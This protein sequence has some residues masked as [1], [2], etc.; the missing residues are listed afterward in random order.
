MIMTTGTAT[1]PRK[2]V[3][4]QVAVDICRLFLEERLAFQFKDGLVQRHGR[5]HTNEQLARADVVLG[6]PRLASA[7][8]HW[9]KACLRN[10]KNP[11]PENA[12]KEAVCSVEAAGRALF[13]GQDAKTLGDLVGK[14]TGY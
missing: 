4:S 1:I 9:S 10:A 2:E 12:V 13:P 8:M 6:D 3:Q 11:D 5:S 14:I 7:R